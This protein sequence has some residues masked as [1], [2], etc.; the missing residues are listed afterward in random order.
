MKKDVRMPM[1]IFLP[2][3]KVTIWGIRGQW[4]DA[5]L[6]I[7]I[8]ETAPQYHCPWVLVSHTYFYHIFQGY[9]HDP[10][11]AP[12]DKYVGAPVTFREGIEKG[13]QL[14]AGPSTPLFEQKFV[15][16]FSGEALNEPWRLEAEERLKR[17]R[18]K[19]GGVMLPPSPAKKHATPGDWHGCFEKVTY[20]SPAERK[21]PKTRPEPPNI[22][23]R[24]NPLGGPGYADIG[25]N[26]FPSYSHEPYDPEIK[27]KEK[28]VGRFLYA[29]APL[30]YFPPD[31]YKDD[32]PGPTY[33]RP[34]EVK[35]KIIGSGRI[36]VPFPKKP[37]GN[38]SGCFDKFPEY[39]SDPYEKDTKKEKKVEGWFILGGPRLRTKYTNSI[40]NQVT[41]ISC[42]AT[43]YMDYQPRVYSLRTVKCKK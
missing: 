11:P 41:R 40:I 20:F 33:V 8:W 5:L 10:S 35:P 24:P 42:N 23:T 6:A 32:A 16:I 12:F 28:P 29:S 22:M 31:P 19:I 3:F 27:V 18:A 38:H 15:R 25:I 17:D 21:V 37:G 13:R 4:K 14:L 36:Y 43:N 1:E 30:D 7:L 26:P 9:F 2:A 34:V 39:S